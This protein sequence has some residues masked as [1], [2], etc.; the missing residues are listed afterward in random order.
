MIAQSIG[1]AGGGG[2]SGAGLVAV[3]GRAGPGIERRGRG[4]DEYRRDPHRCAHG[5]LRA[6]LGPPR[7]HHGLLGRDP[8]PKHRGRRRQGRF[9]HRLVLARR[10]R[11]WRRHRRRGD[12]D[13][14]GAAITT[15]SD[16]S[17]G[18]IAQD[19]GGGG[20]TGGGGVAFGSTLAVAVGGAGG[21]GGGAGAVAVYPTEGFTI[22]TTGAYSD[23]LFAQSIGGGGGHGGYAVSGAIGD[24]VAISV[25]KLGGGGGSGGNG[26]AVIVDT[27]AA[28]L[29][30]AGQFD[31]DLG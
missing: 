9:G 16:N 23:G 22:T 15:G 7:L 20:G 8:R 27:T 14:T 28:W 17:G 30:R 12:G 18:L 26:A 1:G 6:R 11:R 21:T 2:G 19:I 3:G 29:L 31:Q 10:H 4:G 5:I 24:D 13:E 25:E